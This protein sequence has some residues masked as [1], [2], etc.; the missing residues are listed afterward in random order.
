MATGWTR[1]WVWLSPSMAPAQS[2]PGPTGTAAPRFRPTSCL[3]RTGPS[4]LR[5]TAGM[6]FPPPYPRSCRAS[7]DR[8]RPSS[9]ALP[10]CRTP[11]SGNLGLGDEAERHQRAEDHDVEP[12]RHGWP[13][14]SAVSQ[15]G[16]CPASSPA[17]QGLSGQGGGSASAAYGQGAGRTGRPD[18]GSARARRHRGRTAPGPRR[19]AAA[20]APTGVNS[21]RASAR[22]APHR[23]RADGRRAD[24][25]GDGR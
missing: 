24:S 20:R 3:P 10:A 18:T 25:R 23:A 21:A 4:R 8:R 11:P 15:P 16:W 19:G 22:A 2:R 13:P 17:R 14:A 7:R 9:A 6:R 1:T 12:R 5:R